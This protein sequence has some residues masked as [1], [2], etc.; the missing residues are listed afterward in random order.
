VQNS[1]GTLDSQRT[2]QSTAKRK[3][4]IKQKTNTDECDGYVCSM[5]GQQIQPVRRAVVSAKGL[6]QVLKDKKEHLWLYLVCVALSAA[7][8]VLVK[9]SGHQ[10]EGL[11]QEN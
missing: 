8:N 4:M 6:V 7:V 3:T 10:L 5:N 9:V 2:F 11:C 1:A